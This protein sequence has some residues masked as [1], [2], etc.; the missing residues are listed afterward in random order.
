MP[1]SAH[2]TSVDTG[3]YGRTV[4]IRL[5]EATPEARCSDPI[6]DRPA[7]E[8]VVTFARAMWSDMVTIEAMFE[9]C[10]VQALHRRFFRPLPSAPHGYV[11]EVLGDRDNHHAFVV[12]RGDKTIGLAELHLEGPWSGALALIIE[13]PYQRKGVGTAAL[14]VLLCHARELG[15]RM[16]TAD[17]LF[18]NSVVLRALRRV[19]PVSVSR[20]DDILHVEVDLE[21]AALARLRAG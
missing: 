17:V 5:P 20:A 6:A 9:R 1:V 10:S 2:Q 7:H 19:G 14:Q 18:E 4:P 11:E 12:Q 8:D 21:S 3:P 13:D 15:L 16:L